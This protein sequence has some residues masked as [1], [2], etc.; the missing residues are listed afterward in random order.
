MMHALLEVDDQ[1]S[2]VG[3]LTAIADYAARYAIDSDSALQTA[4]HCLIDALCRGLEALH[5]PS[6]AS[7][8]GP[9]VPGAVM[10]G[11]ARVPGTSL[12]LD[13]AQAAFCIGL[14]LTLPVGG[15]PW[16][17]S[18]NGCA[19]DP[20]G[21]ILAA[22]DYQARKATM[23][24]TAPLKVRDLLAA[25]AKGLEIQGRLTLAV[26]N[27]KPT[28]GDTGI[29]AARVAASAIVTAQLGG[30]AAQI[31]TAVSY[32]CIEGCMFLDAHARMEIGRADLARAESIGRAVRYACQ[33][34]AAGRSSYLKP[35]DI[36]AVN[37]AGTFIGAGPS[38]RNNKAFGTEII[39]RLGRK[40]TAQEAAELATRFRAAVERSFPTRQAERVKA[41][42]APPEQLH[43]LPVNELFAALVTNGAR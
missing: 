15:S 39:D 23:E 6:C 9:L 40:N 30:T 26:E 34:V 38:L 18:L 21:A 11:G 43:D 33:A 22:A 17:S 10:P 14:M 16:L 8:I 42:F 7:L 19:S 31:I 41:L 28:I 36:R 5:D 3:L 13:P 4:R 24:G 29:R 27:G 35:D 20:F 32:A 1:T 37:L 2:S 12:E 25:L